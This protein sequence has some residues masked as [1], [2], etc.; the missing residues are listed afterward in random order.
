MPAIQYKLYLVIYGIFTVCQRK[1]MCKKRKTAIEGL[2][3]A[4]I[5]TQCFIFSI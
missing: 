2:K 3:V 5:P 4:L 1:C